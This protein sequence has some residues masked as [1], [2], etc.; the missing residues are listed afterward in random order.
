MAERW[1]PVRLGNAITRVKSILKYAL[2]NAL[3]EKPVRYGSEFKKPDKAVIRRHRASNGDRMIEA[4]DLRALLD[5][6]PATV[7]AMILLGLNCGF[8]NHDIATLPLT[9]VDLDKGWVNF[10]RPKTGIERRCPL[11]PETVQAIRDAI[12]ERPEPKEASAAG[13]VFINSR[14]YPFVRTTEKSRT[15]TV[16]PQFESLLKKLKLHRGGLGFY[17]LR[18]TFRTVADG[19]K[20]SVAIDLIMGHADP[21]MGANYRHGVDD[22]RLRSVTDHVREWLTGGKKGPKIDLSPK[23]YTPD[24][25]DPCAPKLANPIKQGKNEGRKGSQGSHDSENP[26]PPLK[27]FAG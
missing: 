21:S 12:A 1:G 24:S 5:A 11:W 19:S 13:L 18:H 26:V 2:D 7:R 6:A 27:L 3:L 25:C 17:S 9:A 14:G 10:P 23:T 20:D 4:T 8:G 15:D 22:D 16:G